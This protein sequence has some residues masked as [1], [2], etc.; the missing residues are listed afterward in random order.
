M[1]QN[2]DEFAPELQKSPIESDKTEGEP[3]PSTTKDSST[4]TTATTSTSTITSGCRRRE[5]R[6]SKFSEADEGYRHVEPA[7]ARLPLPLETI[8]IHDF[9]REQ[10]VK[11]RQFASEC[12]EKLYIRAKTIR[13]VYRH[14]HARKPARKPTLFLVVE[15]HQKTANFRLCTERIAAYL[16]D[17][18][19]EGFVELIDERF[20]NPI[21]NRNLSRNDLALDLWPQIQ[22]EVAAILSQFDVEWSSCSL[23][24]RNRPGTTDEFEKVILVGVPDAEDGMWTSAG[25]QLLDLCD[26][27]GIEDI[28]PV[29]ISTSHPW[30]G[31]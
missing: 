6:T 22:P 10:V 8:L 2:R 3:G 7:S 24:L 17:I 30:S 1:S 23:V 18:G 28:T 20:D 13:W 25:R 14:I 19:L 16:S 11:A 31:E 15:A 29:L 21:W 4:T 9:D 5:H 27:N 12:A 26:A